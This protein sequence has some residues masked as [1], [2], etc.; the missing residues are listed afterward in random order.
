MEFFSET[1]GGPTI[2]P[3]PTPQDQNTETL[4]VETPTTTLQPIEQEP[5]ME[6]FNIQSENNFEKEIPIEKNPFNCCS[7]EEDLKSSLRWK[8]YLFFSIKWAIFSGYWL[9]GITSKFEE[10]TPYKLC[11]TTGIIAAIFMAVV[12]IYYVIARES[13][14]SHT[15]C[16]YFVFTWISLIIF[17]ILFY[18]LCLPTIMIPRQDCV[19][20]W[21]TWGND[22]Y[23]YDKSEGRIEN[24]ATV[25]LF[26]YG[27]IISAACLFEFLYFLIFKS[28]SN[29]WIAGSVPCILILCSLIPLGVKSDEATRKGY[30]T[31]CGVTIATML[32][33]NFHSYYNPDR[34][35]EDRHTSAGYLCLLV[36]IYIF[37]VI[38]TVLCSGGGG[39]GDGGNND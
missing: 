13:S 34:D 19:L 4:N 38:L 21:N 11:L 8:F 20:K 36:Y 24:G 26:I 39:N 22:I 1:I 32:Y 37:V 31:L 10:E 7:C 35:G 29:L 5:K 16:K 3:T 23:R 15:F 9:T 2:Q 12:T 33:Y 6:T 28:K 14:S 18:V 30:Y 27:W 25:G 17:T